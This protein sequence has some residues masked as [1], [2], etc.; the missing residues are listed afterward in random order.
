MILHNLLISLPFYCSPSTFAMLIVL[1]VQSSLLKIMIQA[2]EVNFNIPCNNLKTDQHARHDN[3]SAFAN[4]KICTV[5]H[6]KLR[7][8]LRWVT[9]WELRF[10]GSLAVDFH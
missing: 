7:A 5:G 4:P 8:D 9:L 1:D 2:C 6:K 3:Y 10:S